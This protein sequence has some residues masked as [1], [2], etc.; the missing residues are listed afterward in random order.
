MVVIPLSPLVLVTV[1]QQIHQ[2]P[3]LALNQANAVWGGTFLAFS[4]D[5]VTLFLTDE[6]LSPSLSCFVYHFNVLLAWICQTERCAHN[7]STMA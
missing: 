6:Y 1:Q 4:Q 3:V 5:E 7:G 2:L